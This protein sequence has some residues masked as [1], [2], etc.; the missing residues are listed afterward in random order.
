MSQAELVTLRYNFVLDQLA[1]A[2][3]D[4]VR[5]QDSWANQTR[6]PVSYTHLKA[7]R[8]QPAPLVPKEIRARLE[9]KAPPE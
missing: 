6:I 5:T 9:H 3:G 2:S 4:F 7:T 1:M 8:V